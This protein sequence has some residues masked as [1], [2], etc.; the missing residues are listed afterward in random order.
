MSLIARHRAALRLET[1]ARMTAHLAAHPPEAERVILFG[2]L[3]RGD[4]DGASDADVLILGAA[5]LD[6]S[7]HAAA[8]RG[9]DMIVRSPEQWRRAVEER[10]PFAVEVEEQ[11][12]ELWR[13]P[14]LP[15]P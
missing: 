6:P 8:G 7:V 10:H 13:A 9:V 3:A 5:L 12:V 11:G 15:A 2:S 1:I 4:F 14:G